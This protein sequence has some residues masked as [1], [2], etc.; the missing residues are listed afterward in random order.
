MTE[1]CRIKLLPLDNQGVPRYD[2]QTGEVLIPE[3]DFLLY[4]GMCDKTMILLDHWIDNREKL[5]NELEII[6]G[7]LD[8]WEYGT[9]ISTTVG[10]VAGIGGGAAIIT[11]M[12]VMPPMAVA[13]L[14]VGGVAAVS[15]LTTGI[16]KVANIKKNINR[17]MKMLEYD[18]QLTENL[19]NGIVML[20]E[21]ES[22][23]LSKNKIRIE[24]RVGDPINRDTVMNG[25]SVGAVSVA[26][27]AAR[28]LLKESTV[29]ESAA[30]K[31]A[32]H[33]ATAIGIAI[34]V[35][36]A[37]QSVRGL[38]KGSHSEVAQKLRSTALELKTNRENLTRRL[39]MEYL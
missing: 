24:K 31:G 25:I 19:A 23:V 36:T 12:I 33:A 16:L 14:A 29:I 5:E 38:V 4:K 11:G 27:G 35:L 32:V 20:E 10:S 3:D 2:D 26:G 9:N 6:A 17:A 39:L 18:K 30:L 28:L 15:N 21:T 37:I 7:E 13:G 34:D 1:K 22:T 8:R